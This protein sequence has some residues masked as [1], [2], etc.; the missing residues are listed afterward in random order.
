VLIATIFAALLLFFVY[1]VGRVLLLLFIAALF[2][3]YLGAI[4]EFLRRRLKVPRGIGLALALLL[5]LAGLGGVGWLIVPPMLE[6]M[7]GLLGTLPALIT[8]W[9]QNLTEYLSRFPVLAGSVPA[10]GGEAGYLAGMIAGIG[11]Y[12]AG[13]F[14]YLFSGLHVVIDVF[15]VM[16]MGIYM[17]L[18]PSLYREGAV[19]LAPP[20]HRELVRDIFAELGRT[21]RAWLVGQLIAMTVLGV[22]TYIGLLILD[23]PYALA[24]GVF[25]AAV[26]IIPFFGTLV[27][28]LLPALFVLPSGGPTQ[29]LLVVL[30]GVIV[31]LLEAN[32]IIPIIL[33]RQI[34]LPPVLSILSVL[35]MAELL[36]LIGLLVA[37]PVL[38]TVLVIVRRLYIHRL[39]EG[40][41]FRRSMRDAALEIRLPAA[42]RWAHP[43]AAELNI[44][45][46]LERL[47]APPAPV[48]E[49]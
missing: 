27:S 11:G 47:A 41:G 33:D 19:A 18:R 16:V 12:F 10:P 6:Q 23:V 40:R 5:T 34:H 9:Q 8:L 24:F 38:A 46:M 42:A 22:L 7:Q 29:A 20:V 14:P 15:S 48:P 49:A 45:A 21:L 25:T 4:T 31:H 32:V 3:L 30:L 43:S 2:S 36:G 13:L 28:T 26:A 17:T 1:S 37:V 39:L 35:V 44:T